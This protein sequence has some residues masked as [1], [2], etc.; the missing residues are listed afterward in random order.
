MSSPIP[1]RFSDAEL[2]V[3]DKLVADGIGSN[4]SEVVRHAIRRL[5]EAVRRE[6]VGQ[7][8]ASSYRIDPQSREDNELAM[9]NAVAMT[10]AEPW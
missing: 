7:A 10:E 6:R 4:R 1:T 9:A 8:I 2:A 3:I 5:D